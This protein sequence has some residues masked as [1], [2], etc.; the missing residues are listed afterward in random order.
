MRQ[1]RCTML[2]LLSWR[3]CGD[4]SLTVDAAGQHQTSQLPFFHASLNCSFD[5]SCEMCTDG[6]LSACTIEE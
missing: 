5:R 3:F 1:L 4:R 6:K 2:E